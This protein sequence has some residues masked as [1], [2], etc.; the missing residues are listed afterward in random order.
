MT[1]FIKNLI[2]NN[3]IATILM[4]VVPMLELKGGIVFARGVGLGFFESLGLAFL[5]SVIV[6]IPIF[7][8]LKPVLNLLKKVSWIN[9]FACKVENYFQEK[10]DQ[11]MQKRLEDHKKPR[12]ESFF[13]KLGVF[14]F[15][16]IPLPL[17]GVW[18]GTAIAVFLN[19]KFK[20]AIGPICL[21]N[22]VAGLLISI[23]AEVC[24]AFGSI[25]TLDYILY[26]LLGLAIILTVFVIIKL[27]KSKL[28]E[29]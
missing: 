9:K 21:G 5:G 15:I 10:A 16:A 22:L 18:A 7:F 1:E 8:L 11:T 26:G 19:L 2:G 25:Q 13:K 24:L 27:S 14:I 29:E 4:S 28:K 12:K 17:T 3:V 23:L 20:E 6:A